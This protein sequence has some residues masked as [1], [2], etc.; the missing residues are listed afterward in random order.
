M[1]K[2]L[3]QNRSS[4]SRIL[5]STSTHRRYALNGTKFS[6][7]HVVAKIGALA[8]EAVQKYPLF[9][10]VRVVICGLRAL[11]DNA[12]AASLPV[13]KS[14]CSGYVQHGPIRTDSAR[15]IGQ[16]SRSRVEMITGPRMSRKDLE[17]SE[18]WG[19]EDIVGRPSSV[20]YSTQA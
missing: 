18:I 11:D 1:S 6:A 20:L 17:L 4:F 12:T 10:G 7:D 2:N 16:T 13:W 15:G 19:S 14:K 8:A 5:T 9:Q 3:S